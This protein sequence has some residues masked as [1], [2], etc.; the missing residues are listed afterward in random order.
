MAG[1]HLNGKQIMREGD[2]EVSLLLWASAVR[3]CQ[4]GLSSLYRFLGN[5]LGILLSIC[6]DHFLIQEWVQSD[7]QSR[8]L[9]R[10]KPETTTLSPLGY[11]HKDGSN[12]MLIKINAFF[13]NTIR[14]EKNEHKS[15]LICFQCLC[16]FSFLLIQ[17]ASPKIIMLLKD[18]RITSFF[19]LNNLF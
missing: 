17:K 9:T 12:L 13:K 8:V 4:Y 11:Y 2:K 16:S 1:D 19:F 14:S 18:A 5:A 7:C 15:N 6:V 3:V 10:N